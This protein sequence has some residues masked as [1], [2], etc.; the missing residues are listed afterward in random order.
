MIEFLLIFGFGFLVAILLTILV[1][2]AIY[3]RIVKLTE[4]RM[5][6]TVPLN[7][8]E[9]KGK[10]DL[11]RAAYA[12][13]NARLASDLDREVDISTRARIKADRLQ[14]DLAQLAGGK[15][16]AEQTIQ[17][18]SNEVDRLRL[19]IHAKQEA[20]NT[21]GR[22]V[23]E[24]DRIRR[25]GEREIAQMRN[26][27]IAALTEIENLRID[28]ATSATETVNLNAEIAT[29]RDRRHRTEKELDSL[30]DTLKEIEAKLGKEQDEH[31]EARINLSA[32]LSSLYNREEE[33]RQAEK[34]SAKKSEDLGEA[35][36]QHESNLQQLLE[37]EAEV[38]RLTERY[39]GSQSSLQATKAS[40]QELRETVSQ[41]QEERD[42]QQRE[43]EAGH[44][45]IATLEKALAAEEARS[46]KLARRVTQMADDVETRNT[47]KSDAPAANALTADAAASDLST[48]AD[49]SADD[50]RNAAFGV[51]GRAQNFLTKAVKPGAMD[52]P[53]VA[54]SNARSEAAEYAE[55]QQQQAALTE[56]LK[57]V[58][59]GADEDALRDEMAA[60]AARVVALAGR[61]EGEGSAILALLA[62]EMKK[63]PEAAD[64]PQRASLA[65]RARAELKNR[66]I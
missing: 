53:M 1:A 60:I 5:K 21:L 12:S 13:E 9:V 38:G 63:R 50:G 47:T 41:L 43:L 10:A 66:Q 23:Q 52:N 55:L 19:E 56:K 46:G 14:A 25:T 2:P 48:E 27:L 7:I 31:N 32:A 64:G 40:L 20:I 37:Y 65:D 54:N 22:D 45:M 35:R 62:D 33:V 8:A 3:G 11:A 4:D 42:A 49:Q 36:R 30:S 57:S 16:E 44:R 17:T 59:A 15:Q 18:L 26:D 24:L 29:E 39:E 34:E 58:D 28:L 61:R 51:I 6:A